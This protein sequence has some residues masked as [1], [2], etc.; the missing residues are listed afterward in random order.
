MLFHDKPI[1]V[2]SDGYLIFETFDAPLKIMFSAAVWKKIL[3]ILKCSQTKWMNFRMRFPKLN[4]ICWT[5][6]I[7][8]LWRSND[9]RQ[10]SQNHQ[11]DSHYSLENEAW[12]EI[13]QE[14]NLNSEQSKGHRVSASIKLILRLK[15]HLS[16]SKQLNWIRIWVRLL[17]LIDQKQLLILLLTK[18]Q[19]N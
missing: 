10:V 19:N 4:S 16:L 14:T 5:R 3:I 8:T 17:D 13:N 9:R 18:E 12:P 11:I 1:W 15:I 6:R 2:F 7:R